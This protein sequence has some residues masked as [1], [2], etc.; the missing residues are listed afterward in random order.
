MTNTSLCPYCEKQAVIE[1]INFAETIK[2]LGDKIET[3]SEI[4]Q[5][6][7][8]GGEFTTFVIEEKNYMKVYNIYRERHNILPADKITE[9]RTEL[10]LS[11]E[12][13]GL[14]LNLSEEAVNNI[15]EG[16]PF[17]DKMNKRI[18]LIQKIGRALQEA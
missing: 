18:L 15:E 2:V 16:Y 9:I 3:V 6:S 5:C 17:S 4:L 10:N 7:V 12:D 1:H 8:C 11:R 14:L 13:F